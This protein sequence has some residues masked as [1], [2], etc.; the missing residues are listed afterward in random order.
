MKHN[1]EILFSKNPLKDTPFPFLSLEIKNKNCSPP[2]VGFNTLHWHDDLQ[3]ILVLDGAINVKTPSSSYT[4]QKNQG[5]FLNK[6]IVHK[7]SE[8][9]DC[10]YRSF[11]FPERMISQNEHSIIMEFVSRYTDNPLLECIKIS[12]DDPSLKR[13]KELNE[14]VYEDKHSDF[15][16][17]RVTAQLMNLWCAFIEN[18]KIEKRTISDLEKT[19]SKRIQ[20]FVSFIHENYHLE[21]SLNDIAQCANVSKVECNRI[22]DGTIGTTPYEYLINYRI[23]KSMELLRETSYS[24]SQIATKVGYN[25]SSHFGKF[26]KRK[27][28]ISPNAYRKTV[29]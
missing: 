20:I 2:R 17:Y 7:I 26:F 23:K 21:I 13:L 11:I 1:N 22:F 3:F 18:L 29:Q 27:L 19:R 5:F 6:C 9:K 15:Y 25:S 8:E 16:R 14:M 4:V 24:I 28:G 10:H 12:N